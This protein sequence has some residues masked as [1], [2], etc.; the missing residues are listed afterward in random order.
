L[1]SALAVLALGIMPVGAQA[2]ATKLPAPSITAPAG[3]ATVEA[4]PAFTWKS[5]KHADRYQVQI[6]ADGRFTSPVGIFNGDT[7]LFTTTSTAATA[8]KSASDGTYYWRVRALRPSGTVGKWSGARRLTK[9]WTTP[10]ALQGADGLTVSWPGTPLLLR[11]TAVPQAVKYLLTVATDAGMSNVVVGGS[12]STVEVFGTAF[13]LPGTLPPGRYYW[14]VVPVDAEGFK[15]QPSAI[16]HFD[17]S[18]PT[19]TA[20][21]VSDLD[22]DARVFDPQFSWNPVPGAARYEVEVNASQD[23]APNSRWCCD[24]RTVGT[25][26]S[27][28]DV[29]ANNNG[30]YVRVR[31][32]DV[33]GNAGGWNVFN[34]T[35]AKEFD[36]VTPTIPHLRLT[37]TAG[38]DHGAG[39][40]TTAPVVR[41]D[42][43]PGAS[44][45]EVQTVPFVDGSGCSYTN[46][47]VMHTATLGWTPLGEGNNQEFPPQ[48]DFQDPTPSGKWCLRVRALTDDDAQGH[49]VHS[50]WTNLGNNSTPA[51]DYAPVSTSGTP[52]TMQRTDYWSPIEG[53][54]GARTP[55]FTWKAISG[56]QS[57]LVV[58]ARDPQFTNIADAAITQVPAYAPRSRGF[59]GS[60]L[61]EP[62]TDETTDYYWAVLPASDANAVNIFSTY[63]D[64]NPRT[65]D[66]NSTPPT[67]LGPTSGS[68]IGTQPTF[69]WTEAEGVRA[70]RLQV[71]SDPSFSHPL[72]DIVT[73]ST[74]F[75]S[76]STYPAD[77][78]LYW[79]VRGNDVNGNGL[80]W[81]S[82][83]TF[84]RRLP[85]PSFL[86]GNPTAG[87]GLPVL[88]WSP[89][90]GAI[91]Y[92][93][94]S[95]NGDGTSSDGTTRSPT[96]TPRE[97]WGTGVLHYK[98]RAAFPSSN[99]GDVR[100]PYTDLQ[101]FT[102]TFGPVTGV[103]ALRSPSR[104]LLSW[105]GYTG[106]KSYKAD[107]STTDSFDH[108]IATVQTDGTVWAPD[109][110]DS[111]GGRLYYRILPIDSHGSNGAEATGTFTLPKVMR[112][113]ISGFLIRG[114]GGKITIKATDVA[115]HAVRAG[116]VTITG[117][118]MRTRRTRLNRHGQVT[119]KLKPR[120]RG[121][122]TVVVHKKGY[123]D[124]TAITGAS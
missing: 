114:S 98:V 82:V 105:D 39:A 16:G 122:V 10:P 58:I 108:T 106:A 85:L 115:G 100:G 84:T 120:T 71:A 111:P 81:S 119:V 17:W 27:P 80:N 53:E 26:L 5:V 47:H 29:L 13:A 57:Y 113:T 55:L 44:Q 48:T 69:Q 33:D 66:K 19:D 104:V 35:F 118:A 116:R 37:D 65:F 52:S 41:W 95:D 99:G 32:F 43:V 8:S 3:G 121:K 34:G 59:G 62:L 11:W 18:W 56:A 50:D 79:R 70:Y 42:A 117:A 74:A 1:T 78:T 15:G 60:H 20:I 86:P 30:Y 73:D 31:A 124:G 6:A 68:D 46:P 89:V 63:A 109:L 21:T 9:A 87:S 4:F 90:A 103:N 77:T 7:G 2:K 12:G 91:G 92:D 45:Y 72:D 54:S 101:P 94:H 123:V 97:I 75:T 25:S 61:A 14:N 76:L 110:K 36:N 23:F 93:I 40:T 51:F 24:D 102:R 64:N 67:P 22:Q 112:I 83:G 107:I 28:K 49:E 88:S 38:V 96:F